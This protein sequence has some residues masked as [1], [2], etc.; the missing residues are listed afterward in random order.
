MVVLINKL[1]IKQIEKVQKVA[2]FII[3]GKDSSPSYTSNLA[4]LG[5][6]PLE[7][8]RDSLCKNLA[9]KLIKHPAHSKMFTFK[10]GRDTRA[11]R[12]VIVPHTI[13]RRYETSSVPSLA[14]LINDIYK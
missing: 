1:L 14:K 11:G 12:K 5:L 3:L 13:T 6:E 2:C 10:Q 7:V 8:R 4:A 9:K